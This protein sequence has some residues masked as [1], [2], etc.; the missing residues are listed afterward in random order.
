MNTIRTE[1]ELE[2]ILEASKERPVLLFKHS[3]AC[4]ISGRA[5]E[6]V[7]Q[8]LEEHADP[9]FGFAMIV[10][11]MARPLSNA[12]AERLGIE[13]ESPQAIVV[14]NGEVVWSTSHW[15]ITRKSLAEALAAA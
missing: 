12:V 9:P 11:Q 8:F 14:R 2:S 7:S 15:N 10:V 13:H 3:N 4:P 1:Q 6:E 5:H